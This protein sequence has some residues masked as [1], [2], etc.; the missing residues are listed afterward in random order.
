[1]ARKYLAEEKEQYTLLRMGVIGPSDFGRFRDFH[2]L[3]QIDILNKFN[4]S[5]CPVD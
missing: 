2:M 3:F 4:L 1:M 5:M